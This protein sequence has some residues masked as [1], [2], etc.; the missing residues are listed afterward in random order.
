MQPTG[1]PLFGGLNPG[2]TNLAPPPALKV[3]R[4]G[5]EPPTASFP[6]AALPLDHRLCDKRY[7]SPLL[8]A[9]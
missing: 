4:S 5:F 3:S 1:V 2:R 9:F 7:V 6:S 8:V